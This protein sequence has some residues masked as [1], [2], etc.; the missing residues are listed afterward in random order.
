[1]LCAS[2]ATEAKQAMTEETRSSG[3][4]DNTAPKPSRQNQDLLSLAWRFFAAPQTLI[5]LLGLVALALMLGTLLPQIPPEAMDDPQTWL[6]MQPG[7]WSQIGGLTRTLGLH[8]LYRSPG[9]RL[10]LALT[11]LTLSVWLVDSAGLA[12]RAS[13][14]HS[15]QRATWLPAAYG[16]WGGNALEL[17][18]DLP[19][20]LED[21]G[22]QAREHLAE[23]GFHSSRVAEQPALNLV[24]HKRA[25]ALWAWPLFYGA[26]L[27]V[28]A[29]LTL[30][31]IWGWRTQDWQLWPGDSHAVGH[32]T[33]YELRLDA[34][35]FLQDEDGRLLD[36][37]SHVTWLE[38]GASVGGG[39]VLSGRPA[40]SKGLVARA[41]GYTPV[42]RLHGRDSS[43]RAVMLQ[44][45]GEEPDSSGETTLTF[46]TPS[47]QQFVLVGDDERLVA[48]SF[49]PLSAE[50][51]PSL[52]VDFLGED[53]AERQPLAVLHESG[54]VEIGDTRLEV[55]LAYRPILRV[56]RRPGLSLVV[57]GA[58]LAVLALAVAWLAS[59]RLLWIALGPNE[60][61]GTRL[62]VRALPSARGSRW[63]QQLISHLQE[64]FDD[65]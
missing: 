29:G 59:P 65:A 8:D 10:L 12:W 15:T 52:H 11:G 40:T 7:T 3:E 64:A 44:V 63:P 42:V 39:A 33:S 4:T 58:A 5:C 60:D 18:A 14:P 43:G 28:L 17:R 1:L 45:N 49:Q 53:G 54:I 26:V 32:G 13:G 30:G 57:G 56:E 47:T 20:S 16:Y 25:L 51:K 46:P 41:M 55:M 23:Q 61:G 35:D 24:V 9:L 50:G 38:E 62:H 37:R 19:Q 2:A 27:L 6:A 34:F 48:L 36:Y 21:T 31:A 22:S